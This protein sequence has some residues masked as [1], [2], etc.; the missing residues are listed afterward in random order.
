MSDPALDI[1]EGPL[2]VPP[3]PMPIELLG[4]DAQLQS[5]LPRDLRGQFRFAFRARAG[6]A[7][8]RPRP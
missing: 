3:E 6:R 2:G 1:L 4:R 5:G 7:R 8:I